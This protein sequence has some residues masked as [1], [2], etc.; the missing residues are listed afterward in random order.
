MMGM[1]QRYEIAQQPPQPIQY[2]TNS[3]L[4]NRMFFNHN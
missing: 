2:T 1:K 4:L 3:A